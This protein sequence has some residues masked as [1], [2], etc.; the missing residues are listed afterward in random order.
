MTPGFLTHRTV[1]GGALHWVKKTERIQ[2][3]RK[4]E[5]FGLGTTVGVEYGCQVDS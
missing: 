5:E 4:G 1:D 2:F 3:E